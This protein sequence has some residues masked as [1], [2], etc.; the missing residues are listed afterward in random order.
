VVVLITVAALVSLG[1]VSA[2]WGWTWFAP[3]PEPRTR[4]AVE[5]GSSAFAGAL[6]GLL[7]LDPNNAAPPGSAS[8]LLG[9]VGDTRARDGYAAV[10]LETKE[11]LTVQEGEDVI[12]GIWLTG[13]RI[14][15]VV[16]ERRA[17]RETRVWPEKNAAPLRANR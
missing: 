1:F 17:N 15:Q 16:L 11:I 6:F 10:Q 8:R 13:A 7:K 14:D 2:Y 5:A 4:V 12:P 9:I 3:R